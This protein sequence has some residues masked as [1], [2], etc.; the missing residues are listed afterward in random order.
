MDTLVEWIEEDQPVS[1][2]LEN[3]KPRGIPYQTDEIRITAESSRNG[4]MS[5][6]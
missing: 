5:E 1:F 4:L 2:R 3:D 6:I